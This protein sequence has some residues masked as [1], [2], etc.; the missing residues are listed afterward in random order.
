M[1]G[2][3]GCG[4]TVPQYVP[5]SPPLAYQV[6]RGLEM[7]GNE[8]KMV[9]LDDGHTGDH[10]IVGFATKI[11]YGY[12]SSG[13][14][15]LMHVKDIQLHSNPKVNHGRVKLLEPME[16]LEEVK[17]TLVGTSDD[18][19][20]GEPSMPLEEAVELPEPTL[21]VNEDMPLTGMKTLTN[22]NI[23]ELEGQGIISITDLVRF[24]KEGL[25]TLKGMSVAK[26]DKI[27]KEAVELLNA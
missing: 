16:E 24:G 10:G 1:A 14:Q 18:E 2:C 9:V 4:G 21:E 26:A 13:E 5:P 22:R 15:F 3:S 7:N 11:Q 27:V 19:I 6:H 12:R 20:T 25:L 23:A 17:P 8:Y